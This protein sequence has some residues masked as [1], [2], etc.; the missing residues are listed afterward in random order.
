MGKRLTGLVIALAAW[1]GGAQAEPIGRWFGASDS[2]A[3]VY[4]FTRD[5]A[6][7]D[8]IQIVCAPGEPRLRVLVG[9]ARPKPRDLVKFVI[10]GTEWD[11]FTN[12][13]Q[14]VT[15]QG[16]DGGSFIGLWNGLRRGQAVR[17]R[18]A[19][20]GAATFSLRGAARVLPRQPCGGG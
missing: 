9:S 14:E 4:G 8:A 17:V 3:P 19:S 18:L 12:D 15:P 16:Q 2:G 10:D 7:L 5:A 13:D 20:G 6:G 11:L 1:S